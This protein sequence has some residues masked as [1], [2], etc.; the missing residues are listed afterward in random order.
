MARRKSM[1]TERRWR[2]I[3]RRQAGGGLSVRAFC[4]AEGVSGASFYNWRR[5]LRSAGPSRSSAAGPDQGRA[6]RV[7]EPLF[8]PL[9]LLEAAPTLE[10]IHPRGCRVR[11]TGEVSEAALRRVIGAL[12]EGGVR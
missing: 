4:E 11:V 1:E 5:R 10:I 2:E 12:D 8:V 7:D 9:A 6:P 3:V